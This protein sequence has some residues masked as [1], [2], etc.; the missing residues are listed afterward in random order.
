MHWYGL[1]KPEEF[2]MHQRGLAV[3]V[4]FL[5]PDVLTDGGT[6]LSYAAGKRSASRL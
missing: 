2:G 6:G 4:M 5:A 1:Q 3:A